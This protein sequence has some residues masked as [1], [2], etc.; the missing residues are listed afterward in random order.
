[1]AAIG[2]SAAAQ[3]RF[4][5]PQTQVSEIPREPPILNHTKIDNSAVLH[6]H[7]GRRQAVSKCCYVAIYTQR[8]LAAYSSPIR[9]VSVS[10]RRIK[11]GNELTKNVPKPRPKRPS[12]QTVSPRPERVTLSS[13]SPCPFAITWVPF[14]PEERFEEPPSV[15]QI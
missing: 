1:M 12:T 2:Y 13:G 5:I 7:G 10:K 14:G 6:E 4:V 15:L 8:V 11:S 3:M 9:W